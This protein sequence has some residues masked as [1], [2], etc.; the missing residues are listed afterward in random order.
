[1]GRIF[2][3]F[4]LLALSGNALAGTTTTVSNW[5]DNPSNLP[6]LLVYTPTTLATNPAIIL[7]VNILA[8]LL[9]QV[10]TPA[11]SCIPVVDRASSTKAQC[12]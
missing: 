2:Q 6:A 8:P 9:S 10:L 4:A 3:A 11:S 1:M 12:R 5:G 7:D